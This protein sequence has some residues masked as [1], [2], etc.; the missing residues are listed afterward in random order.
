MEELKRTKY[1]GFNNI[2]DILRTFGNSLG[3]DGLKPNTIRM[4]REQN[5]IKCAF[6]GSKYFNTINNW[7]AINDRIICLSCAEQ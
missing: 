3:I 1:T 2:D 4:A 6:C 7:T 5:T